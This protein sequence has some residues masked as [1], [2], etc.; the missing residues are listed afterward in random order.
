MDS[1]V[2]A[3]FDTFLNIPGLSAM[4]LLSIYLLA[5]I[6]IAPIVSF[7]PFFGAKLSP[8]PT[9]ILMSLAFALIFMP[10]ILKTASFDSPFNLAFIGLAA[11]ELLI[12]FLISFLAMIPFLIA[13]TAGLVIDYM[14]G[15]SIMQMQD[16]NLQ[17]SSSPIG[18]LYNYILI[19]IF[20][21]VD[22][23][24]FFF[25]ALSKAF[26]I[27]PVNAWLNPTAFGVNTPLAK[28]LIDTVN[29]VMTIAIQ[30]GAP[31][32]LA[33]LMAEMFLGI[34]NRLA[35]QVQIA[36]LGMSLKSLAGLALL[37]AGWFFTLKVLSKQT[38]D[39]F[40]MID[41]LIISLKNY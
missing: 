35:Q 8:A 27:L 12:G 14:R 16:P 37:W 30:L 25:D 1:G 32:I 28:I 34:A 21:M 11:K 36:F 24:F 3:Y 39:W 26:D 4:S 29:Q 23:P 5:A 33:I 2:D 17:S 13:T 41:T 15:A 22:G 18:Q 7:V 19:V 9:R 6:R 38:I 10:T 20:F 31:A 40:K